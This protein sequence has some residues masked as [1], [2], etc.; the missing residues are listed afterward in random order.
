MVLRDH[1]AI[2]AEF[3]HDPQHAEYRIGL[4]LFVVKRRRR[5]NASGQGKILGMV[6]SLNAAMIAG[7]PLALAAWLWGNR[8]IPTSIANRAEREMDLFFAVWLAALILAFG[9]PVRR[10]WTEQLAAAGALCMALPLLNFATTGEWA[11]VYVRQGD[12]SRAGVEFTAVALGLGVATIALKTARH[13]RQPSDGRGV[14]RMA[15]RLGTG[16]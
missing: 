5:A 16:G 15:R 11:G 10:V 6:D 12:W 1:A 4:A 7:L 2:T 3:Q 13:A 9:R 14:P 8:L